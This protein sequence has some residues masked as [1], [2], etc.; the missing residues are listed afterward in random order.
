VLPFKQI[1]RGS[2]LIREFSNKT[3]DSEYVWHRD[4][5]DRYVKILEGK[6]WFIQ[7]YNQVPKKLVENCVYFIPAN[8]Y[9]RVIKGST[10]LIVRITETSMRIT[11][12]QLRSIIKEAH[13][14]ILVE[15]RQKHY[16]PD[17]MSSYH[18]NGRPNNLTIALD[19]AWQDILDYDDMFGS[20]RF[21][22]MERYNKS[23]AYKVGYY[24]FF[25]RVAETNQVPGMGFA[26][27]NPNKQGVMKDIEKY[28]MA[29]HLI[30]N[31]QDELD[32]VKGY[33]KAFQVVDQMRIGFYR[34]GPRPETWSS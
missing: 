5:K 10:N 28:S 13:T 20:P 32:A 8:N 11:R 15:S 34:G 31:S 12:R 16:Q 19:I 1:K 7:L 17:L 22:S 23:L 2:V 27:Q 3:S 29:N 14:N 30:K 18:N 25:L 21:K 33:A 4:K 26:G 6:D 9:H 24:T